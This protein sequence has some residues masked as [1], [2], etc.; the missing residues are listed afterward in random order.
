MFKS[1]YTHVVCF[2]MTME[3]EVIK[4]YLESSNENLNNLYGQI[5]KK[6]RDQKMLLHDCKLDLEDVF[7]R[8]EYQKSSIAEYNEENDWLKDEI[9]IYKVTVKKLITTKNR[10]EPKVKILKKEAEELRVKYENL[11]FKDKVL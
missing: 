4:A 6:F 8:I 10:Q 2:N 1:N 5:N 11:E 3:H 7:N 9:E